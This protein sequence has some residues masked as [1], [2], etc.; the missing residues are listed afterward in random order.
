MAQYAIEANGLTRYFGDKPVVQQATF[1]V[2]VG[3]VTGLL[4]LNGAGKSTTIRMLMGVLEPTRGS[5]SLLGAD[6]R[7]LKPEDRVRVGYT[8]EGHY[9]Y[10]GLTVRDAELV[11]ADCFP[12]WNSLIFQSTINRFGISPTDRIRHLSRGQR[13]GVSIALTL[14]SQPELLVLDDPS[15]GLDP[16]ARRALNETILEFIEPGDRSVLLS[17]HMLDDIERVADRVM[18]MVEGR[19]VVN[20]TVPD[21][22]SRIVTWSCQCAEEIHGVSIPGLISKRRI[23]KRW[24]FTVVDGMEETE[25][26]IQTIGGGEATRTESSFDEA[27]VAYLSRSRTSESFLQRG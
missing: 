21:F 14:S 23:G 12:R 20:T 24:L 8:I 6:S 2:P 10:S 26:V 4:G 7:Q 9:L 22:L 15:L 13:A 19:I 18:I 5:C 16:V 3:S 25:Q 11:Q 1:T 17:S 27:V